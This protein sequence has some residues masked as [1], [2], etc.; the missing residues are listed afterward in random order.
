MNPRPYSRTSVA[1]DRTA[2]QCLASASI[3]EALDERVC[4]WVLED[5][6]IIVKIGTQCQEMLTSRRLSVVEAL[7]QMEGLL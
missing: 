1:P 7:G 2:A 6:L 4:N 5:A 3:A